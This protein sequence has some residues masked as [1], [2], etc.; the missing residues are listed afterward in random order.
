MFRSALMRNLLLENRETMEGLME[1]EIVRGK[2]SPIERE[3]VKN[4]FNFFAG[5]ILRSRR[6][7]LNSS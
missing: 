5:T 6:G 1:R 7:F 2:C 3:L 4:S